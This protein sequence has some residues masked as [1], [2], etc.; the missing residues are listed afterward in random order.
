MPHEGVNVREVKIS[1][2]WVNHE[3]YLKTTEVKLRAIK[4]PMIHSVNSQASGTGGGA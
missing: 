1:S 3:K 2:D 4:P